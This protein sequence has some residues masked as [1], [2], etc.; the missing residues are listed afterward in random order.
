MGDYLEI[1][2]SK[3]LYLWGSII[4]L[5]VLFQSILF[6]RL[7]WK[8]GKKLGL[9]SKKMLKGLRA[10]MVSAIIPSIPIVL[11][12]IAMAP[13]LGIPFPWI[14]LSVIGSGPYELLAAGIGADTMGVDGLGA[15]GYTRYVFANSV[16]V[17]TIGAMWSG[18]IVFFF[19]KRIKKGYKKIEKR[20]SKWM[21]IITNA[22]FFGVICV[23][24]AQ[25]ITTG[26]LALT[27]MLS[28][29]IL[30][31]ICALLVI[32]AKI[33]WLKEFALAISMIGAMGSAVLFA[34]II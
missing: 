6:I 23:F 8:E 2:N 30:M 14:R 11:T 15:T 20:D 17:M 3:L 32:K 18:T 26:G 29:G 31:T 1:A 28:G 13:V 5:F 24:L 25:P 22:A 7:A 9:T 10:G 19:I 12:L 27:T 21:S 4:V 33:T 34:Q 16:W